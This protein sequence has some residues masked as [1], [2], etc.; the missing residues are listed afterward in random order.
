MQDNRDN[1]QSKISEFQGKI[2]AISAKIAALESEKE[3][4]EGQQYEL[5]KQLWAIEKEEA[6]AT[7]LNQLFNVTSENSI[8]KRLFPD[9]RTTPIMD[10]FYNSDKQF[11][12]FERMFTLCPAWEHISLVV[13][14]GCFGI[15]Y[16]DSGL[17]MTDLKKAVGTYIDETTL[18]YRKTNDRKFPL[19]QELVIIGKKEL[20]AGDEIPFQTPCVLGGQT[21]G[22]Q[23]GFGAQ[24]P[25]DDGKEYGETTKFLIIG[26]IVEN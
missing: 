2:D 14:K 5:E 11:L 19:Y 1:I 8:R 21:F 22:D 16:R 3:E 12:I 4:L 17:T 23:T 6:T 10:E 25:G 26:I 20:H 7:V 18:H 15:N 13:T 24:Y 9:T